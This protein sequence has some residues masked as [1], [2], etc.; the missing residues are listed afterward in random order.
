MSAR[1]REP[2]SHALGV[3]EG[4]VFDVDGLLDLKDLWH[5]VKLPGFA[6]LRDA[7]WTPVT[8]PRLRPAR[9]ASRPT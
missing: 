9:T 6:D 1:L 4:D 3:E 2:L 8:Q 7:P 5:I